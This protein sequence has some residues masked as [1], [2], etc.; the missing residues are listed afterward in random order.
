MTRK[1]KA[2]AGGSVLAIVLGIISQLQ[3]VLDARYVTREE[4]LELQDRI[5]RLEN[6]IDIESD[7]TSAAGAGSLGD[8][9]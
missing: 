2:V 7:S 3:P 8:F 4:A 9:Y 1:K 5:E 6:A